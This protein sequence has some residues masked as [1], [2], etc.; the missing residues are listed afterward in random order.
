[1]TQEKLWIFGCGDLGARLALQLNRQEYQIY[2]VRRNPLVALAT[3]RRADAVNWRRGDA[4]KPENIERLLTDGAD[5]VLATFTPDE[6]TQSGYHRAYISTATALAKTL[7]KLPR[8]PRLLIWV[9]STRVYGQCGDQWIDEQTPAIPNGFQGDTLLAAEEIIHNAVPTTCVVRFAGIYGPGR[10]RLLSQVRAGRCA[11]PTP[12]QYSNRI[13]VDDCIGFLIHL[14]EKHKRGWA[15]EKLYIG[16]DCLPVPMYELQQWL[17]KTMG[18]TSAHLREIVETSERRS[19][20][21]SNRRML[22]SGYTMKYPD[23]KAGY[24]ALLKTEG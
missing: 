7:P 18:Y 12:P 23:Y 20:K 1:M 11:P 4:T 13:H 8:P 15:P 24:S 3:K 10:D 16:A 21:L 22:E 2:G 6:H 5:V 17:V 9:S 14:M 19:K